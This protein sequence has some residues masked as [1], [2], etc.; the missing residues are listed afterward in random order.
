MALA[1]VYMIRL[2]QRSMHNRV[3][4]GVV[5]RASSMRSELA[6]IAPIAAVIIALGVYPQLVLDRTEEAT[7]AP[8][9][10]DARRRR[11]R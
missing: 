4:P 10:T 6:T 1:A 11:S 8:D 2:F 5:S 3:G 9:P 7:S